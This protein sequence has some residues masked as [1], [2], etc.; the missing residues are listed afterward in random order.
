[1]IAMTVIIVFFGFSGSRSLVNIFED[2][3]GAGDNLEAAIF[4]FIALIVWARAC[5]QYWNDP[6]KSGAVVA[7]P[8]AWTCMVVGALTTGICGPALDA[9]ESAT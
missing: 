6:E 3:L 5:W 8:V 7:A 2:V 4:L 9:A 1:M